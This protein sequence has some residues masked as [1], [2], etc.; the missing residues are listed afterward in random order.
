MFIAFVTAMA[1]LWSAARLPVTLAT[2]TAA[3]RSSTTELVATMAATVETIRSLPQARGD[4]GSRGT[5][6]RSPDSMLGARTIFDAAATVLS[7]RSA[8]LYRPA[9]RAWHYT[10]PHDA[11]APPRVF[12][13]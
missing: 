6:D 8:S 7:A 5:P 12:A 2:G 3:V 4:S 1:W 13:A 9:V 11:T 10:A